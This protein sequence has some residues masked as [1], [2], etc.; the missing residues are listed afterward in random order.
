[1]PLAESQIQSQIKEG[2]VEFI[3]VVKELYKGDCPQEDI[4]KEMSGIAGEFESIFVASIRE[5]A[6]Q[7]KE[8]EAIAKSI[9]DA[10]LKAC[11][12]ALRDEETLPLKWRQSLVDKITTALELPADGAAESM[13]N[14]LAIGF[15][16]YLKGVP[17]DEAWRTATRRVIQEYYPAMPD[18]T[19]EVILQIFFTALENHKEN[20]DAIWKCVFD[21]LDSIYPANNRKKNEVRV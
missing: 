19:R 4:V 17:R 21:A 9:S 18:F 1:M 5:T 10:Y 14:F 20:S 3:Q 7:I 6:P 12:R 2:V 16:E 8:V 11:V 13:T 15:A